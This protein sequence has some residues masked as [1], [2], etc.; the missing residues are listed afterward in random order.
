MIEYTIN[1]HG[2]LLLLCL[3]LVGVFSIFSFIFDISLIKNLWKQCKIS[4]ELIALQDDRIKKLKSLNEYLF[5]EID[6]LSDIK[7]QKGRKQCSE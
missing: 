1:I 6:T 5:N 3:A 4:G 2:F 7:K